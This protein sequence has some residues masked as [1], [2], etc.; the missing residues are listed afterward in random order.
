MTRD[1]LCLLFAAYR[2]GGWWRE[3]YAGMPLASVAR[4][5]RSENRPL[6]YRLADRIESM[7]TT[8]EK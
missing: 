8:Q 5:L 7:A 2:C 4:R 6:A 3:E 1:E